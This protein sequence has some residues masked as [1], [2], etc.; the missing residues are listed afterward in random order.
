MKILR[1]PS[2]RRPLSHAVQV[3]DR[4]EDLRPVLPLRTPTMAAAETPMALRTPG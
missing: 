1:P 4:E 2:D 3:L